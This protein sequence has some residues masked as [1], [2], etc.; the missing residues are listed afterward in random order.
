MLIALLRIFGTMAN[1]YNDN[2]HLVCL[3]AFAY[4]FNRNLVSF[5]WLKIMLVVSDSES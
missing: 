3:P 1:D 2:E 5:S 4:G